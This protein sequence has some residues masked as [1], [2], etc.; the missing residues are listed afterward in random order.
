[1]SRER[2][3]RSSVQ[4]HWNNEVSRKWK[5]KTWWAVSDAAKQLRLYLRC[6]SW[7]YWVGWTWQ[8]SFSRVQ[9]R[10]HEQ[11][12]TAWVWNVHSFQGSSGSIC[13]K[14]NSPFLKFLS[15]LPPPPKQE[16][17]Q[18]LMWLWGRYWAYGGNVR[19]DEERSCPLGASRPGGSVR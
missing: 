1:M 15:C 9:H 13:L 8:S 3:Q 18:H 10:G 2:S 14:P 16:A 12:A 17:V 19:M 7:I 11:S 5:R 4:G 6:I